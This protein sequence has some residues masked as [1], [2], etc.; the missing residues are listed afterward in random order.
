[1]QSNLVV[2]PALQGNLCRGLIG[3][4][5][6]VLVEAFVADPSVEALDVRVVRGLAAESASAGRCWHEPIDPALAP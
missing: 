1:M 4:D 5:E 3:S 6:P 2:V